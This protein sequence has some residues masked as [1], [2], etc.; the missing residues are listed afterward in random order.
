MHLDPQN[1][2][3]GS[4]ESS[5]VR[6]RILK[7]ASE[8]LIRPN[9]RKNDNDWSNLGQG[10]SS[11]Q[12]PQIAPLPI[13]PGVKFRGLEGKMQNEMVLTQ[14]LLTLYRFVSDHYVNRQKALDMWIYEELAEIALIC[15]HVPKIL[16]YGIWILDKLFEER[17]EEFNAVHKSDKHIM[18]IYDRLAI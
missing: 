17:I 15:K 10:E 4:Y 8:V 13:V 14:A 11:P 9:S 3:T 5:N 16:I 1:G 6:C 18:L 2:I 7:K 12:K